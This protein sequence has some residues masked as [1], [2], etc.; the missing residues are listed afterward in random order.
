MVLQLLVNGKSSVA[1]ARERCRREA[2]RV[3]SSNA[4]PGQALGRKHVRLYEQA[5]TAS[6]APS[7]DGRVGVS[8]PEVRAAAR[9]A[10]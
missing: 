10:L 3:Y 2:V 9:T 1:P 6:C 5:E 8:K 7:I 4:K